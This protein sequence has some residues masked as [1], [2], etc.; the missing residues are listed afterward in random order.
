MIGC[1]LSREDSLLRNATAS[2]GP[3]NDLLSEYGGL[4]KA[5]WISTVMFWSD[6]R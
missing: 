4:A 2:F 6:L 5:L 3:L 1:G